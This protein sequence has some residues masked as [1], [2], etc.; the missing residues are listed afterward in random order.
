MV[1]KH[2]L[3]SFL[4]EKYKDD[5]LCDMIS[6]HASHLLLGRPWQ[7]DRK[8]KRDELKNRYFLENDGRTYT[9]ASLS[10]KQVYEDQ[11]KLKKKSEVEMVIQQ[12]EVVVTMQKYIRKWLVR[13]AYL[14]LL[15]AIIFI[16][17]C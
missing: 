4:I 14:K 16:Q 5:V 8:D 3:I 2:V 17:C 12:C 11:L 9:L 7:F 6:M 1:T 15:L 13:H 10:P